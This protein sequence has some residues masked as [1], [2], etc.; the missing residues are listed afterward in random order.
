M[1]RQKYSCIPRR[2]LTGICSRS[3]AALPSATEAP[4]SKPSLPEFDFAP[5]PY[6]G[7]TAE[8]VQLLRWSHISKT[9][10]S[11]YM[12][13]MMIVEGKGQY[14]FDEKGQRYLDGIA[15]MATVSVGHCHPTVVSA[16]Q[17]QAS[18][19]DLAVLRMSACS[20]TYSGTY[21]L[22]TCIQI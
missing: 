12:N 9:V 11:F 16:T 18:L 3:L 19:L 20:K 1:L 2:F 4:T 5:R 8:E 17:Q 7:P 10:F 15:G 22:H 13:P 14:V 21:L 6:S